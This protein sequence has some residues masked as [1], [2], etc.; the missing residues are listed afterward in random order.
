[1]VADP[2]QPTEVT[3]RG[4]AS[5]VSAS[6]PARSTSVPALTIVYHPV[7]RRIGERAVLGEIVAGREARIG[8]GAPRFA[9]PLQ[10]RGAPLD[11]PRISRAPFALRP[12]A[13]GGVVLDA[14]G[15]R[16]RLV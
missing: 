14:G 7:L 2:Q 8:R 10:S 3:Q 5:P 13:D 16:T 9:P 6:S 12:R 4:R 15:T 1:M 11:H